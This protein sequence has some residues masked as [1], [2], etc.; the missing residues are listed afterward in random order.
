VPPPSVADFSFLL[1]VLERLFNVSSIISASG[2]DNFRRRVPPTTN[3]G[4]AGKFQ[5]LPYFVDWIEGAEDGK[6]ICPADRDLCG[7]ALAA[8]SEDRSEASS[9]EENVLFCDGGRIPRDHKYFVPRLGSQS[10]ENSFEMSST[11]DVEDLELDLS[12]LSPSG[13]RILSSCK[14]FFINVSDFS[15]HDPA[16]SDLLIIGGVLTM[17]CTVSCISS[18]SPLRCESFGDVAFFFSASRGLFDR[19]FLRLPSSITPAT[20]ESAREPIRVPYFP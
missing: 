19:R 13:D 1:S 6:Y 2:L 4:D 20:V 14:S 3:D 9:D 18:E 10:L 16:V 11:E 17:I 15:G 8:Q 5:P 7:T 12:I